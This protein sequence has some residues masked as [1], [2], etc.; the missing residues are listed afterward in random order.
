MQGR[1]FLGVAR[2]LATVG[3]T[4]AHWRAAAVHAYYALML[5]CR[6][7]LV[8]WG[9]PIPPRQGVHAGVR[10]RFDF[11]TD[12]DLKDIG[13]ALDFLVRLR[14][15]ASYDLGPLPKFASPVAVQRAV[16]DAADALA[17]LDAIDGDPVR[18]VAAIAAIRP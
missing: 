5:E 13:K 10:L 4:E 17:L 2:E 16:Q 3:T 7:A 1:S 6:D 12:Q 18:R 14:N 9:F 8:R 11:A 15:Q